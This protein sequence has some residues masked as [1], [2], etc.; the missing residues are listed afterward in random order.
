MI[1]VFPRCLHHS[2][3]ACAINIHTAVISHKRRVGMFLVCQVRRNPLKNIGSGSIGTRLVASS[4]LPVFRRRLPVYRR[5]FALLPSLKP[6][7]AVGRNIGHIHDC[8]WF[9]PPCST[10]ST[11]SF[12]L[13]KE[14]DTNLA[15]ITQ[16]IMCMPPEVTYWKFVCKNPGTA[17]K[18][19]LCRWSRP[20]TQ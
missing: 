11:S 2:M 1:L 9:V 19:R 7:S 14:P 20:I 10:L 6:A 13:I 15:V 8:M 5:Y 12:R 4:H 17:A 3:Y 16:L 18:Y